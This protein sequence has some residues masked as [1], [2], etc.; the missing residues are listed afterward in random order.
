[1]RITEQGTTSAKPGS[2]KRGLLYD[3]KNPLSL[4]IGL[5][6]CAERFATTYGGDSEF[7]PASVFLEHFGANLATGQS[8]RTLQNEDIVRKDTKRFSRVEIT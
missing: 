2:E 3:R 4:V 7:L 6:H 5:R 1:M 8:Y